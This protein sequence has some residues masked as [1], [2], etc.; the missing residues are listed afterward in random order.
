M[1]HGMVGAVTTTAVVTSNQICKM[2]A[3]RLAVGVNTADSAT[4]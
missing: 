4:H 2:M 3:K 1:L